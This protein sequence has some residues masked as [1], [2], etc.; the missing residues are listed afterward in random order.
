VRIN[1]TVRVKR[2]NSLPKLAAQYAGQTGTVIR[3]S[4]NHGTTQYRI[5]FPLGEAIYLESELELVE[6]IHKE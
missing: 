6:E 2:L 4:D 1:D 3:I 5:A